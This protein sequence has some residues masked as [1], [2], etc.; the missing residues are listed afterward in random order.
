M[1]ITEIE[2]ERG[3]LFKVTF[4]SGKTA[5]LDKDYCL[6]K[7]IRQ[8]SELDADTLKVFIKESDYRRALSRAVWYI[9]RGSMSAKKLREK[10]KQASF[11][12]ETTEKVLERMTELGLIN[13]M[14]FAERLA[15]EYLSRCVSVREAERKMINKGLERETIKA[16]LD[17]FDV[18]PCQQLRAVI[19]KNYRQKMV[20]E[21]EIKKV[22]AALLR[23]GFNYSDVKHVLAEYSE[24]LRYSEE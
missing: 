6:E 15:E 2:A 23:K 24:Q 22:F 1:K 5:F 20:S 12:K 7:G 18:D 9:E 4:D 13:D 14:A 19:N 16:A 3:H 11:Q 21:E 8:D 17:L 10:L